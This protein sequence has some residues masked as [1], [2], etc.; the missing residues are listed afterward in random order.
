MLKEQKAENG[1]G[2]N[3]ECDKNAG[4]VF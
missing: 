4:G 2:K 1:Y 3:R